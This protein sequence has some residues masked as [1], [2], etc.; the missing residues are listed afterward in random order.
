[1]DAQQ[2]QCFSSHCQGEGSSAGWSAEGRRR[3][4]LETNKEPV[5]L[6]ELSGSGLRCSGARPKQSGCSG[7]VSRTRGYSDVHGTSM[8]PKEDKLLRTGERTREGGKP[9]KKETTRAYV[10]ES[11]LYNITQNALTRILRNPTKSPKPASR[12]QTDFKPNTGKQLGF[13]STPWSSDFSG[14]LVRKGTVCD[15]MSPHR[16][17][18]AP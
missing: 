3:G 14:A 17:A 8:F 6:Q 13:Q 5:G 9:N 4:A 18:R 16:P 12:A 1:M 2:M 10:P 15:H 7:G 11:K